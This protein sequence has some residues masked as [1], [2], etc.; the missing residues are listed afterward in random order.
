MSIPA[1][2]TTALVHMDAP[3]SFIGVSARL[4]VSIEPSVPL[5]WTATGT[6][7][8]NFTDS[9]DLDSG[10]ELAITLPHTNQ[11]GFQDAQGNAYTNWYYSVTVVYEKDGRRIA[12]PKRDFQ[13]LSG[14]TT[15][16]LALVP[17]GGAAPV[18]QI[19]PILPVTSLA[20]L[21]GKITLADLGLDA[22]S[23]LS[24]DPAHPGLYTLA[25]APTRVGIYDGGNA[26]STF[27]NPADTVITGGTA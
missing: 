15:L 7:L 14:Q 13:I 20:G 10:I 2:I 18:P 24:P 4:H 19:A 21:N 22:V 5:I 6:P 8:A 9:L 25:A 11:A 17:A 3:V 16:D 23:V 12:F 27:T 1:G 26:G